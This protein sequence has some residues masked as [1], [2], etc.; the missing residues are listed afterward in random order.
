MPHKLSSAE[1][2]ALAH[3]LHLVI[4]SSQSLEALEAVKTAAPALRLTRAK[5]LYTVSVVVTQASWPNKGNTT[6]RLPAQ[7]QGMFL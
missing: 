6:G 2:Q 1:T 5:I 7:V 3:S 4:L